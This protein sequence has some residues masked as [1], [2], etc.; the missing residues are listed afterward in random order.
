MSEEDNPERIQAVIGKEEPRVI[1]VCGDHD[2]RHIARVI[3]VIQM[4]LPPGAVAVEFIG[5][6]VIESP[7]PQKIKER[8]LAIAEPLTSLKDIKFDIGTPGGRS[9]KR[10]ER[11]S[12]EP[13]Y[14][15]FAKRRS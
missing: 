6:E 1:I 3:E 4:K 2:L 14:R 8:L 13:Y 7:D 12:R 9:F 5:D 10:A 11:E 15:R